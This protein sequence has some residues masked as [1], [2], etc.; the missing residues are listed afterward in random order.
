LAVFIAAMFVGMTADLMF[1]TNKRLHIYPEPVVAA[2]EK[3]WKE[4]SGEPIPVVVGGLRLAALVDHYSKV[5]P[6]VCDPEDEIM[7]GLYRERIGKHGALLIDTNEKDFDKFL[8][9]CR[10]DG[11]D[12]KVKFKKF[13]VDARAPLGSKKRLSFVLGYLPPGTEIKHP[14]TNRTSCRCF[15]CM[16]MSFA[17]EPTP[18]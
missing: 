18:N 10:R 12:V 3:F 5:H 11:E 8:K 14:Y 4:R 9:R 7:I 2:A 15:T 17:D 13:S 6:P 1:R 16:Q